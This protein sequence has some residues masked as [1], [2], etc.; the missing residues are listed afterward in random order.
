MALSATQRLRL[1]LR[2]LKAA[3]AAASL[4]TASLPATPKEQQIVWAEVYAPN[5]PDADG[6]FMS[7]EGIRELAY[8]FM[9]SGAIHSF[10]LQH[11]EKTE[12]GLLLVESFIARDNDPDFIPGSWVVAMHVADA[13]MWARIKA[14]EFNGF[15]IQAL[16]YK[17]KTDV[18]VDIPDLVSG[19]TS[20]ASDGHTHTF[21]VTFDKN[22]K[23]KG[24][25]TSVVNGHSHPILAGTITQRVNGHIHRFSAVDSVTLTEG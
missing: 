16:V 19:I 20:E 6:E 11:N 1:P 4:G 12:K 22:G 7:I 13:K 24:G 18:T 21:S 8:Q 2:V 15:S 23:F 10:D 5:R 14:G 9:V 3:P 17:D 25:T